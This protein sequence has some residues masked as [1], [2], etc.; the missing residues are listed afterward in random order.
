MLFAIFGFSFLL[1]VFIIFKLKF[2][3]FKFS[4]KIITTNNLFFISLFLGLIGLLC[5]SYTYNFDIK[6]YLFLT[7]NLSR[8]ERTSLL[9]KA[10]NALPYSI[11]FI[12]SITTL[13]LAIKKVGLN[14]SFFKFLLSIFISLINAPILFSYIIEG[15]RSALIKLLVVIFFALGLT[16]FPI[17]STTKKVYLIENLRI[18]KKVLINRIKII[19]LLIALFFMLTLIAINRNNDW[20][21]SPRIFSNIT[22]FSNAEFRHVNYSIDFALVRNEL[23][24]T[25]TK[26]MFTWDKIIFYPLPTYVYK[27]I[28]NEKK[29]PNVG[30]AIGNETKNYVYGVGSEREGKEMGISLSPIAEGYINLGYFGVFFIGLFYGLA[31]GILQFFYNK[32]SLD[33]ISL[34]DIILLNTLGIVPLIMRSG[35]AGMYNWIFSSS[36]VILLPLLIIDIYQ[37]KNFKNKK[38]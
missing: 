2:K 28:F 19:I 8:P 33:K 37:R 29:P 35:S 26:K 34:L 23:G 14:N 11:F 5:F 18:N 31:I 6:Q 1:G 13:I 32:I 7:S 21:N 9:S 36:F 38:Q 20:R 4:P 30:A 10:T 22:K 3:K 17:D 24:I 25:K 27:G 12:P 15:D 16:N